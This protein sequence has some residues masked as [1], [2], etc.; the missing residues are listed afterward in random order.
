M[1]L[2]H[3]A[4]WA[5]FTAATLLAASACGAETTKKAAEAAG[6]AQ[7]LIKAALTRATDRTQNLGSADVRMTTDLGNG[8]GPVT[9]DGTYSWG[10]GFAFDVEMDTKAANMGQLHAAPKTRTIFV[11]GAYYYDVDPQPSG[12]L[13]G[14][15]WMKIDASAILGEKGAQA[16]DGGTGA[17]SP[18]ASMKGL[19]YANNVDDLGKETVDGQR[20]HHYKAVI[21]QAHMGK[22]KEVYGNRNNP[23]GAMTGGGDS[24]TIEI[25]VNDKDLPVRL[26]EEFGKVTVTMDFGKFGATAAVKAPPAAQTGDLTEAVKAHQQKK[27]QG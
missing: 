6:D 22:F 7:G 21:D 16:L 9:M 1:K 17:G 4:V 10:H 23:F 20:T 25:W 14:K 5:G 12:P 2:K 13:E 18:V 24:I 15:E 3:T 26:T 19:K 27:Q 8:A 11:D